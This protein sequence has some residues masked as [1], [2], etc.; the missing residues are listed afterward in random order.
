MAVV[1]KK[2][3]SNI[4]FAKNKK[5]FN[6]KQLYSSINFLLQV[7][8]LI[9]HENIKFEIDQDEILHFIS[10]I[11]EFVMILEDIVLDL[12]EKKT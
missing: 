2:P 4:Q 7:R 9:V 11:Y 10:A 5:T 12:R 6:L 3:Q 8:N 1:L